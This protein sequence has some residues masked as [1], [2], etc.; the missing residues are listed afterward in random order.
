M[1]EEL[2]KSSGN[3]NNIFYDS[4]KDYEDKIKQ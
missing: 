1:A 3:E 4:V 2:K